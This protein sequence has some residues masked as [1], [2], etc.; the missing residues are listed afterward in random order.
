MFR[1]HVFEYFNISKLQYLVQDSVLKRRA[2]NIDSVVFVHTWAVE[3]IS[4]TMELGA[5]GHDIVS[6]CYSVF[7]NY[8]ESEHSNAHF[9]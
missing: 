5:W 3:R 4:L 9:E 8:C 7:S 6:D 1:I 2:T